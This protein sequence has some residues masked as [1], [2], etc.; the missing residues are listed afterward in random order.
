MSPEIKTAPA[1]LSMRFNVLTLAAPATAATA[2]TTSATLGWPGRAMIMGWM[3]FFTGGHSR[4]DAFFS[5]I[6]LAMGIAFGTGAALAVG[7]LTPVIGSLAFG[8]VVF[9]VAMIVE[10]LG[11]LSPINNK[12]AYF[13]GLITF[14]AAHQVPGVTV[15]LKLA[16]VAAIGSVAAWLAYRWQSFIAGR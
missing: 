3:A 9:V 11:A 1:L 15:F 12:P 16:A 5:Y 8:P 14:F 13:L 6:C 4:K 10:S 7:G 2:A